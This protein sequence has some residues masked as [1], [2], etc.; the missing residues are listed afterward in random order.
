MI[1]TRIEPLSCA[2]IYGVLCVLIGLLAGIAVAGV[3]WAM[4]QA[5]GS[6]TG[7]EAYSE[8]LGFLFG[9]GAIIS[10]PIFYGVFGFV[11]GFL[12]SVI[13]NWVAAR[14]GGIELEFE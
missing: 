6:A 1:L 8:G 11:I 12:S 4:S 13:Y 7:P 3:A 14:I 5:F 9:T 10:Y 2:K